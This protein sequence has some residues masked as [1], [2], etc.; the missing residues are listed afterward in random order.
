MVSK[1]LRFSQL[2][3]KILTTLKNK[4]F[5]TPRY[6]EDRSGKVTLVIIMQALLLNRIRPDINLLFTFSRIVGWVDQSK[7]Y[8]KLNTT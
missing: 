5:I 4:L 1:A 2:A 6:C 3:I 7:L 8:T